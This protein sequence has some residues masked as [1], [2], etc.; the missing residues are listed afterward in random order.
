M[1]RATRP[2]LD[3]NDEAVI[4]KATYCATN[5][6]PTP[7]CKFS[8]SA[9]PK[10]SPPTIP[11]ESTSWHKSPDSS[12]TSDQKDTTNKPYKTASPSSKS[13]TT[14]SAHW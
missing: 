12:S 14:N 11:Q 4:A 10:D 7:L 8:M 6:P 3:P 1:P 2:T 9:S 13:I 5:D